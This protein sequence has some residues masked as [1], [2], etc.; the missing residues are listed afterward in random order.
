MNINEEIIKLWND[1]VSAREIGMRFGKTKD[2]II[3]IVYRLRKKGFS[4]KSKGVSPPTKKGRGSG[5]PRAETK[6]VIQKFKEISSGKK[7]PDIFEL[8]RSISTFSEKLEP[9]KEIPPSFG[10]TIMELSFNDCRYVTGRGEEGHI[11]CAQPSSKRQMCKAHYAICYVPSNTK[12][13]KKR[14]VMK[15]F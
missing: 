15:S 2:A 4:A 12:K 9:K 8:T 11:F 10:K 5:R 1:D 3:G 7:L 6:I 14:S 13:R